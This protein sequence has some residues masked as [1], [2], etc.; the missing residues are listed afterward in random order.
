MYVCIYIYIYMY[1]YIY[2]CIYIYIWIYLDVRWSGFPK[3]P[4]SPMEFINRCD[5]ASPHSLCTTAC[6]LHYIVFDPMLVFQA[7]LD[8]EPLDNG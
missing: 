5:A 1:T 8:F 4:G 2:I 7:T 6:L 3:C